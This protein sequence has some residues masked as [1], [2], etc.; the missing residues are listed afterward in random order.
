MALLCLTSEGCLCEIIFSVAE[1][2]IVWATVVK[3]FPSNTVE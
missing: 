1:M 3:V 2:M